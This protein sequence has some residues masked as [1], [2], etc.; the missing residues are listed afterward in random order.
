VDLYRHARGL[1]A[2]EIVVE[3]PDTLHPTERQALLYC[4]GLGLRVTDLGHFYEKEFEKVH[5][6]SLGEAWF[7]GYD[8]AHSKPV[9]F[10]FKRLSDILLSVAGLL[11][12]LPFAPLVYAAIRLQ[13]GGPAIYTQVRVGFRNEPFRIY[14]FRTMRLDAEKDGAKW[15]KVGDSRVTRLGRLLRKTRLDEVP[16]FWNILMGDMSFVGPRPE[17]PEFVEKIETEVPFYRYR[18]LIK[19]GLTGWAQVNYPYGASIE[20]ARQKLAYDFFYLKY[21]SI[22]RELHIVLRTIV[23]AIQGAR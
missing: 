3:V 18:H 15:A 5:V 20:D 10:A 7:W 2:E 12:F 19:P 9:F 11:V 23:A 17:R 13:D 16:Q 22:T 4:T 8:P 6:H 1:G 21:A 14:K